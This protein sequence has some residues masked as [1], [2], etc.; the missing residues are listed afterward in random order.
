MNLQKMK[1]LREVVRREFSV[2]AAARALHTCQPA[3]SKQIRDLERQ[4]GQ[5]L[6]VRQGNRLVRLTP[7]GQRIANLA[8]TVCETIDEINFIAQESLLEAEHHIRIATIPAHA[9]FILPEPMQ[10]FSKQHPR[11][12]FQVDRASPAE[13]TNLVRSG[14]VDLGVTPVMASDVKDVGL[15]H[16]E[17][18]PRVVLVPGKYAALARKTLTLKLL[19]DYPII[20]TGRGGSLGYSS[21]DVLSV[22]AAAGVQ[23]N[24]LLSAPDLD[25]VKACVKKGLGIAIFPSYAY[26]K[27][28]D[29][30]IKA[31][32]ASHLFPPSHINIVIRVDPPVRP[33]VRE[34]LKLLQPRRAPTPTARVPE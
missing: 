29:R 27:K 26:D 31:V 11:T 20:T 24:I 18:Y 14:E 5:E 22:F 3:I 1:Y 13:I 19:T 4:L 21:S 9:R 34:F 32:D 7:I 12:H 28:Q 30:E 16:Y 6:F 33:I 17:S 25:I 8:N 10:Q 23:P 15:L 2:S